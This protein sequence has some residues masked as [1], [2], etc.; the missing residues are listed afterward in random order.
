MYISSTDALLARATS[1]D[2]PLP[3]LSNDSFL[4]RVLQFLPGVISWFAAMNR[5]KATLV[6]WKVFASLSGSTQTDVAVVTA[7]FVPSPRLRGMK[8][9]TQRGLLRKVSVVEK[10]ARVT[11]GS[12]P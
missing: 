7:V 8:A 1:K 3:K 11:F 4:F 12:I 10:T 6:P 9:K 2:L 5:K